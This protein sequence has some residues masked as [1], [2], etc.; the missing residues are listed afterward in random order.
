MSTVLSYADRE[1]SGLYDQL[2][3]RFKQFRREEA[4]LLGEMVFGDDEDPEATFV[5]HFKPGDAAKRR[6]FPCIIYLDKNT[7]KELSLVF[8]GEVD[9]GI[10]GTCI[11]ARG[12]KLGGMSLPIDDKTNVRDVIALRVPSGLSEE[13]DLSE[14]FFNQA[15]TL[16]DIVNHA[17]VR[18]PPNERI[19]YTE[20]T[21]PENLMMGCNTRI[22]ITLPPKYEIPHGDQLQTTVVTKKKKLLAKSKPTCTEENV[23]SHDTQGKTVLPPGSTYPPSFLNDYGDRNVF[24]HQQA[25]LVQQKL[26]DTDNKLIPPWEMWDKLRPGTLVLVDAYLIC[27]SIPAQ[28]MSKPR[29]I[30]HV[31]S[32]NLRCLAKSPEDAWQPSTIAAKSKPRSPSPI[33]ASSGFDKFDFTSLPGLH[34]PSAAGPSHTSSSSKGKTQASPPSESEHSFSSSQATTSSTASSSIMTP[35]YVLKTSGAHHGEKSPPENLLEYEDP[36]HADAIQEDPVE[37]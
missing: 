20:F 17:K 10:N 37:K 35:H 16:I 1:K 22:R 29:K 9:E 33:T 27:W 26:Y 25:K 32:K 23:T 36:I 31:V 21:L 18:A 2:L 11:T 3:N 13:S 28:G 19:D 34:G 5:P 8:F 6:S 30:F 4:F 14:A 7:R 12:N 24:N 15:N